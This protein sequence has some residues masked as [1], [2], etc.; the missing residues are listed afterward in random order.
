MTRLVTK[1]NGGPNLKHLHE[2][3]GHYAVRIGVPINLRGIVGG[4]ELRQWL[5]TD[6]R[7]AERNAPATIAAFYPD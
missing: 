2:I 4:R 7:A 6:K 1:S 3:K 5:S